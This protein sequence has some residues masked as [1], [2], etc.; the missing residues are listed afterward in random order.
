MLH[1]IRKHYF[2]A[3]NAMHMGAINKH[4]TALELVIRQPYLLNN[5]MESHIFTFKVFSKK[6]STY[7]P[8]EGRQPNL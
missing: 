3:E 5:V 4:F 2:Y 7:H 6:K 1:S 8:H